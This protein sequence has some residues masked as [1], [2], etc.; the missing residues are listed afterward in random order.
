[1]I[2]DCITNYIEINLSYKRKHHIY[3]VKDTAIRLARFY[4]EDENKAEL[5]ALFHDM[6]R[7]ASE[8]TLN[9]YVKEFGLA[10]KYLNNKNLAHGKIA[11]CVMKRDYAIQ[12]EELLNAVSFHT[13]GR[14]GMSTLE[15]IIYLADAI[16]PNRSYP[17]VDELRKLA[18]Q[19]LDDACILSLSRTIDF[20]KSRGLFLDEDTVKAKDDLIKNKENMNEQQ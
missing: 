1:M 18:F 15:K 11:A 10:D 7:G 6:F 12:D 20:V 16:E 13:T 9:D 8:Q 3:G 17:G 19:N 5:A 4:H 14:A 2:T